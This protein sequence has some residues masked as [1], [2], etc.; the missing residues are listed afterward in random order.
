MKSFNTIFSAS[1]SNFNIVRLKIKGFITFILNGL[2]NP[3]ILVANNLLTYQEPYLL[4]DLT[5]S[6]RVKLPVQNSNK[7]GGLLKIFPNPAKDFITIEYHLSDKSYSGE[8][9]IVDAS[10][11]LLYTKQASLLK[12]QFVVDVRQYKAGNY[13]VQLRSD[14]KIIATAKFIISN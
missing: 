2:E 9:F 13:L 8:F 11:R 5:K 3:M 7:S 1:E 6:S 14:N 4:P 10:G 12:D